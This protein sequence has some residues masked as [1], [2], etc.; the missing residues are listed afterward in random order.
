VHEADRKSF[1]Q[2]LRLPPSSGTHAPLALYVSRARSAPE[3]SP[4]R[5]CQGALKGLQASCVP[6]RPWSEFHPLRLRNS[7]SH[8]LRE[9]CADFGRHRARGGA[10][11]ECD[12]RNARSMS[13][14]RCEGFFPSPVSR[15]D[16]HTSSTPLEDLRSSQAPVLANRRT[17]PALRAPPP[18]AC[19]R[20]HLNGISDD[21]RA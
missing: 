13:T 1:P 7:R 9:S 3:V 4:K 16:P 15:E 18:I 6:S 17:P 11:G 19:K 12:G 2:T 14:Y 5:L 8:K 21:T 10:D 20:E